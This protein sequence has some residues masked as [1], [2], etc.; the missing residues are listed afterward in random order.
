MKLST[1]NIEQMARGY[2]MYE[3]AKRG[4]NVQ[5]TDS[6]FPAYDLLV[7]SPC[8]T[9]FGIDVKGMQGKNFWRVKDPTVNPELFYVLVHVPLID[10][11]RVFIMDC[12]TV[13][14]LCREYKDHI[15]SRVS[16]R[17]TEPW[18][19]PWKAP[20][21]YKDCYELLPE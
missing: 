4:Y 8:G 14:K 3:L 1:H 15:K 2:L 21:T 19:I 20:F 17:K 10:S 7:V 6:R 18:G 5:L 16:K 11:P 12:A 9:H 13:I